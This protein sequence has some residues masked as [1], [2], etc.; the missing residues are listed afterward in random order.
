[1]TKKKYDYYNTTRHILNVVHKE[2]IIKCCETMSAYCCYLYKN[3][4]MPEEVS[5]AH[6][7]DFET[8]ATI[9][10]DMKKGVIK[11]NDSLPKYKGTYTVD[12]E[13]ETFYKNNDE[14]KQGH[15][16]EKYGV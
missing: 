13:E 6:I 1:M 14:D 9:F 11:T 2:D 3:G 10:M 15:D 16:G 12:D 5:T 7:K 8:M 4:I